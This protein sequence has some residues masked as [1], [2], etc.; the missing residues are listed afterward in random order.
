MSFRIKKDDLVEVITGKDRGARGKVLT[1]DPEKQRVIIEGIN[2]VK[3]HRRVRATRGGQEGG[4][5]ETEAPVH[6]SNVMLVDPK[7]DRPTRI[8]AQITPEG[9]KQ[10]V[11]KRSG[12]PV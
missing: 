11:A 2:L 5:M 3:R 7:T 9:V 12:T 1:V 6:I 10:R 4:I 8:G